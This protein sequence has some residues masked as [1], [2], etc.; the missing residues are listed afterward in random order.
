MNF[1][2]NLFIPGNRKPHGGQTAKMRSILDKRKRD[3]SMVN[4]DKYRTT[5]IDSLASQGGFRSGSDVIS[6]KGDIK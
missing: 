4:L 6:S 2:E 5:R 3:R 1:C